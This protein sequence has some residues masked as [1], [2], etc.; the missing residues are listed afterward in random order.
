MAK[1]LLEVLSDGRWYWVEEIDTPNLEFQIRQGIRTKQ[2]EQEH[3]PG[4][5]LRRIRKQ[6][7][8][9]LEDEVYHLEDLILQTVLSKDINDF[10]DVLTY[11]RLNQIPKAID[12]QD[13]GIG[14]YL[15]PLFIFFLYHPTQ[16]QIE[17]IVTCSTWFTSNHKEL[18]RV[19]PEWAPHLMSVEPSYEIPNT[20]TYQEH[21]TEEHKHNQKKRA[22][23][24]QHCKELNVSF[25]DVYFSSSIDPGLTAHNSMFRTQKIYEAGIKLNKETLLLDSEVTV[26]LNQIEKIGIMFYPEEIPNDVQKNHTFFR[27]CPAYPSYTISRVGR[28]FSKHPPVSINRE[29]RRYIPPRENTVLISFDFSQ[30]QMRIAAHLSQ[31]PA[32]TQIFLNGKDVYSELA[33]AFYG[34]PEYREKMKK[35]NFETLFSRHYPPEYKERFKGLMEWIERI[36]DDLYKNKYVTAIKGRVRHFDTLDVATERKALATILQASEADLIK[37]RLIETWCY[38]KDN[39]LQTVPAIILHDEIVFYWDVDELSHVKPIKAILED[40][41]DAQGN[42]LS[43]PTP[44]KISM[45]DS[46]WGDMEVI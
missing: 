23:L 7:T 21:L 45:S 4:C 37:E 36:I 24:I 26:I 13:L 42:K 14:I 2:I 1:D 12:F 28:I 30:I 44:V 32:L 39:N 27:S 8:T 5:M 40:M 46:S 16:D 10:I 3:L 29:N 41:R 25:P 6:P 18:L 22:F 35:K 9:I 11:P 19:H 31:C 43:V 17:Q 33:I 20:K 15:H 34:S 38:L